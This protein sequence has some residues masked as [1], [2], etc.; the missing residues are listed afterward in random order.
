MKRC[1]RELFWEE[2]GS[3]K[4]LW[5]GPW[6][7]GGDFNI[8]LSPKERNLVGRLSHSMRRFIEVLNELG[9]RDL[10]LQG[11]PF[12]WRG[13]LNNQCMF[14]LDRFLVTADWESQFSNVIQ[15]TLPRPVSDHCPVLL[16]SDGIKSGPSPF[17]FEKF[18]GFKDLLR[19]WW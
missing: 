12:T 10:P 2:L 15:S 11:V 19:G 6:S 7:I 8:V 3:F 18:E 17:R 9:I 13:G 4:G 1:K 16:D 14:R 5:E